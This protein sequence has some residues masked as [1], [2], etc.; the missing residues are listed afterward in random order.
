MNPF[1]VF[2]VAVSIPVS[3]V[4]RCA[5][6]IWKAYTRSD[7]R[8]RLCLGFFAHVMQSTKMCFL[9]RQAGKGEITRFAVIVGIINI[10]CN[11]QVY[12]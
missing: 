5:V 3:D 1:E 8:I 2:G 9:D 12:S 6:C 4:T 11:I 7:V 10:R